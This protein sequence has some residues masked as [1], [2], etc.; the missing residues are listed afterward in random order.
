MRNAFLVALVASLAASCGRPAPAPGPA[1][2]VGPA[3]VGLPIGSARGSELFQVHCAACHGPSGRGDGPASVYLFPKPRDFSLGKFKVR[4]TK[5]GQ[6]PTDQDLLGTLERGMPGSAMPSFTHLPEADRRELL[7]HVKSL[8]VLEG[9]GGEKENIFQMRAK[10][11]AI[12]VGADLPATP[13]RVRR[14]REVYLSSGCNA[15]HGDGGRGD[16]PSAATLK[17]DWGLPTRP[18]DFTRGLYKGG[19]APRDVYVR[20]TT[21]MTGTPMPSFDNI[22]DEDRWALVHYVKSLEAAGRPSIARQASGVVIPAPRLPSVPDAPDAADWAS[23]PATEIPL[24]GLWQRSR[25]PDIVR[26]RAAHDGARLSVLLEWEDPSVEGWALRHEDYPDAASVMFS[27]SDPP[28][29]FTMGER[30]KPCNIW[31][32]RM[33]RQVDLTAREDVETAYPDMASDDYPLAEGPKAHGP[34]PATARMDPTFLTGAGAGNPVSDLERK[35]PVQDLVAVGFGTLEVQPEAQ[36][37]V[38]GQG[39]WNAGTWRVV[40][41]RTLS[42]REPN[43]AQLAAGATANVGFAVWDGAAGDR[44]GQKSVTFWQTLKLGK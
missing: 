12:P 29:H 19:S 40:F 44:D 8:A 17:D 20:F 22:T 38:R 30:G 39:A 4:T 31:Q 18:N 26:V 36:Q 27:L 25:A 7:A 28:G 11:E 2:P 3:G 13:D 1:G 34:I 37:N 35:T 21:G 15:C 24:M 16:G 14:G 41:T 33:D 43:D 32:W 23:V 5:S 6:L 9:E 10:P 42:S